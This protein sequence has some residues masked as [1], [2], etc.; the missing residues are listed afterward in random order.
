M[1]EKIENWELFKPSN[2]LAAELGTNFPWEKRLNELV[3][4]RVKKHGRAG[5]DWPHLQSA[6][7]WAKIL[8]NLESLDEKN[9]AIITAAALL[10]DIGY[11][12]KVKEIDKVKEQKEK[13]L[14]VG[15]QLAQ[16]WYEQESVLKEHFTPK[17]WEKVTLLIKEHEPWDEPVESERKLWEILVTVD[18]FAQIDVRGGVK[19]SFPKGTLKEIYIPK[20]MSERMRKLMKFENISGQAK[21][22]A[23]ILVNNFIDYTEKLPDDAK[24][25]R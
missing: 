4:E 17:D 18:S 8:S 1:S 6:S 24:K 7:N 21:Q 25:S 5:Y 3:Y 13:H 15:A 20:Q 11:S 16:E 10:H 22:A 2:E 9:T 14:E 19:P 12:E 23:I